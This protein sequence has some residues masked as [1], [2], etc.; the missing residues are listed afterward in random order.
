MWDS[1]AV[2]GTDR[3]RA[4]IFRIVTLNDARETAAEA[5]PLRCRIQMATAYFKGKVNKLYFLAAVC[6]LCTDV[7]TYCRW[8]LAKSQKDHTCFQVLQVF[9]SNKGCN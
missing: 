5:E 7:A 4:I 3:R 8:L 2:M 6:S 1:L 9:C